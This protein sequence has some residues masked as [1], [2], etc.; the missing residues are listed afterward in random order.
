MEQTEFLEKHVF[1][2]QTDGNFTEEEFENVLDKLEYFGI[3]VYT[4]K[5]S[6]D[7]KAY[8]EVHHEAFKK[9]ATNPAWYK[10]AFLTFKHRQEGL[11]YSAT[12][13]VSN[14]LLARFASEEA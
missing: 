14:K 5:A 13:K 1:I 7:G 9:K 12:Y 6:L 2:N 4:V 3:G 10:K 8:D 11:T